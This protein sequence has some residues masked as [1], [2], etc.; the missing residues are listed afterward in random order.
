MPPPGSPT[1]AEGLYEPPSSSAFGDFDDGIAY[2]NILYVDRIHNLLF[3]FTEAVEGNI[4]LQ[5]ETRSIMN[6]SLWSPA[7]RRPWSDEAGTIVNDPTSEV[8]LTHT[9]GITT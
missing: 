6:M 8:T 1:H 9:A 7:S 3:M 2:I 4:V 5:W